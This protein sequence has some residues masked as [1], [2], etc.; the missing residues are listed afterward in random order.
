MLK[1]TLAKRGR[2]HIMPF[3]FVTGNLTIRQG[4]QAVQIEVA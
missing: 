4:K 1:M 3:Q 2:S